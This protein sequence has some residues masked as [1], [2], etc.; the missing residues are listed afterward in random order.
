MRGSTID[1]PRATISIAVRSSSLSWTRSLSRYARPS[2]P[3]A[4]RAAPWCGSANWLSTI[5]ADLRV[6]LAEPVRDPDP[7]AVPGRRHPQVGDDDVRRLAV[8]RLEQGVAVAADGRDRDPVQPAQHLADRLA[9]QVGVVGE[10]DRQLVAHRHENLPSPSSGGVVYQIDTSCRASRLRNPRAVARLKPWSRARR[11]TLLPLRADVEGA[12]LRSARDWFP[13]TARESGRV[14]TPAR[15]R[16]L[17]PARG[18]ERAPRPSASA[19][20]RTGRTWSSLRSSSGSSGGAAGRPA[21]SGRCSSRSATC[22]G[23][24][25]GKGPTCRSSTA[26]ACS[27]S[28]R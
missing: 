15:R 5:D 27:A 8:D 20:A 13:A 1:P 12:R 3:F 19:R 6:R 21:G 26:S 10:R 18:D 9:H 7:L 14:R 17:V 22:P 2:A 28:R 11:P 4:I 23:R 25:P 24:S 16:L